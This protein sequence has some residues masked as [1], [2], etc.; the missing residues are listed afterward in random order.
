MK[1]FLLITLDGFCFIMH[2]ID[3]RKLACH[4]YPVLNSMRKVALLLQASPA[5]I[6]RWLKHPERKPYNRTA[7]KSTQIVAT[8]RASVTANPLSTLAQ[9]RS[10]L[11]SLHNVEVSKE[12][13]RCVLRRS[14]FSRKR[15]R[16]YGKP[17][18]LQEKTATF[19]QARDTF[20]TEGR[21]FVSLDETSFGRNNS[22]VLQG[23]SLRGTPL[24]LE[25]KPARTTTSSVLAAACSHGTFLYAQRKGSYNAASFAEF[26]NTLPYPRNTVLLL[27]NVAFH[28]SKV[29]HQVAVAKEYTL[30]FVPPYSPWFNPIETAFSIVKRHYYQHHDAQAALCVV[31][32]SHIKG[33]F[34]HAFSSSSGEVKGPPDHGS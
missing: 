10:L 26:V 17:K 32:A 25:R 18:N 12:L 20:N 27:D 7:S 28:H 8:I 15:A 21:L 9:L 29:V 1:H 19:L 31:T 30:L 14:G 11:L 24:R 22:A 16:F 2:P 4:M 3:R 23:Y 5:S 6:C 34:K 13:I 33:A